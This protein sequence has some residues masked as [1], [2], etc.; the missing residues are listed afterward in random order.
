MVTAV[1]ANY[2]LSSFLNRSSFPPG[3]IFGSASSSYQYEGAAFRGGKG[4][5]IWH[6]YTH[7]YPEKTADGSNGD[8]AVNQYDLYKD[9]I[10]IMNNMNLDAY[11]FSIAWTRILLIKILI[12]TLPIFIEIFAEGKLSGGI[13]EEG[14]EH[15]NNLINE[16][17][18]N[19]QEPFFTLFHW[20]VP[21]ASEDEY[22]G[23]LCP[24]IIDDFR[25]YVDICFEEFGDKVEHWITLNEPSVFSMGTYSGSGLALAPGRS[26]AWQNLNYTCGNSSTEPYQLSVMGW[27]L[28]Q[29]KGVNVK[30]YF[31]WSLLDNFEFNSGYTVRFGINFVDYKNG[32]KRYPKLSAYWFTDFLKSD[33]L[34]SDS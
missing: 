11:R 21:Q 30:G 24:K 8:V 28:G 13:N 33:Q 2:G 23:F 17:I 7:T 18:A 1:K 32:L 34:V 10:Q 3:F 12:L 9:D 29:R 25:D 27:I 16:L 20:D 22:G 26:S 31:A 15:Y 14:I 6:N 19:G 5:S 4:Q